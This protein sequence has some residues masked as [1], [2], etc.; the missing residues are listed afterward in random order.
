MRMTLQH[1]DFKVVGKSGKDIPVADALSRAYLPEEENKLMKDVNYLDAYTVEV[2]SYN[3]FG[4]KQQAQLRKET[5]DDLELTELKTVMRKGWPENRQEVNE[6]VRQYWDSRDELSELDEIIFKGDRV[7]I[8]KAMQP[9]VLKTIPE[10]HLGIV[11]CKQLARDSVYWPRMN[12]QIEDIVGKC[13]EC[14]ENRRQQQ[15]SR[16]YLLKYHLGLGRLLQ[17]ICYKHAIEISLW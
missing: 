6:T 7:V 3:I 16:Y 15:K 2:R 1:Y 11:K 14:Q 10:S 17:L 4:E 13:S 5:I 12:A 9:F 8:P